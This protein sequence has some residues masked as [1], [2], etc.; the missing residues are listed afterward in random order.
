MNLL[1][2]FLVAAAAIL[3]LIVAS[4]LYFFLHRSLRAGSA[5]VAPVARAAVAERTS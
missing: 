2:F 5:A 1:A 3:G 4:G